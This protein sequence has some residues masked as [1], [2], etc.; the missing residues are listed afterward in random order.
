VT[1]SICATAVFTCSIPAACSFEA[2][3]ISPTMSVTRF[4]EATILVSDDNLLRLKPFIGKAERMDRYCQRLAQLVP[5]LL[6]KMAS[7]CYEA[8]IVDVNQVPMLNE[9]LPKMLVTLSQQAKAVGLSLAVVGPAGMER[10]L[11]GWDETKEV[12]CFASVAEARAAQG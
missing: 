11:A 2:A 1:W 3:A 5:P 12:P 9:K 8:I 4:T 6:T 10:L 7:A